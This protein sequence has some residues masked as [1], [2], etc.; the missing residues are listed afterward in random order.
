MLGHSKLNTEVLDTGMETVESNN[1]RGISRSDKDTN[2]VLVM[3]QEGARFSYK[4]EQKFIN[5]FT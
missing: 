4:D 5:P 3:T 2:D 1:Y